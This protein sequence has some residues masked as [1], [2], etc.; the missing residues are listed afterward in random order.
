M[1]ISEI[2]KKKIKGKILIVYMYMYIY[3]LCVFTSNYKSIKCYK[4]YIKIRD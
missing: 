1:I 2:A 3:M 4:C